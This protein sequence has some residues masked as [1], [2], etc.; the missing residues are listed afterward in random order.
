LIA[1][2]SPAKLLG[3]EH[4]LEGFGCGKPSL[5]RWLKRHG[6]ENQEANISRTYVTCA[7]GTNEVAGFHSLAMSSVEPDRVPAEV[8]FPA[9]KYPIPVMLLARLAVDTRHQRRK[10]GSAML[11]DAL[12]R[13]LS[14][15]RQAGVVAMLVH[16]LDDDAANWYAEKGFSPSAID[17]LHLFL[18]LATIQAALMAAVE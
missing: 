11:R 3:P 8:T 17:P 16:A 1:G 2:F 7:D 13:T 6:L 12:L 18:S 4:Q 10:L 5:D 9:V 14:A 15:S